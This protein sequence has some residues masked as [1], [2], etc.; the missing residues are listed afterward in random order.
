MATRRTRSPAKPPVPTRQPA[1][2]TDRKTLDAGRTRFGA[3]S[4]LD[5]RA[6]EAR[7][8]PAA[9]HALAVA[10]KA[11]GTLRSAARV[12]GQLS[13]ADAVTLPLPAV[14]VALVVHYAQVL[15]ATQEA[16]SGGSRNPVATAT[17]NL[18]RAEATALFGA[19]L[20]RVR[21]ALGQN[22][23]WRGA[24][25]AARAAHPADGQDAT[26]AKMVQLAAGIEAVRK[27]GDEAAHSLG[28]EGVYAGTEATLRAKADEVEQAAN[29]ANAPLSA[30]NDAPEVNLV[31][32]RLLYAL[33]GLLRQLR[34]ARAAKKTTLVL[35]VPVS[36]LRQL[37]M[38][39]GQMEADGTAADD[40]SQPDED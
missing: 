2:A 29:A 37:G 19:T 13:V 21:R 3:P 39:R 6:F 31:E 28:M 8:P 17:L 5:L 35:R 1:R 12:V 36:L 32:G 18:R 26:A 33:R 10:S 16:A 14:S 11:R 30:Y 15:D 4:P 27:L 7:H 34:E 40:A 9:C 38:A 24:M 22:K 23:L 25:S 20:L